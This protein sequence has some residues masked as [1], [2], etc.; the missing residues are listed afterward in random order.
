MASTHSYLSLVRFSKM[1]ILQFC[2]FT[3]HVFNSA[4]NQTVLSSRM[5]ILRKYY[6]KLQFI[7]FSGASL[8]LV[9]FEPMYL[10]E[11]SASAKYHNHF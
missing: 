2:L 10:A 8:V 3:C 11:F 9:A 5:Q 1:Y 4:K 7:S 6:Y